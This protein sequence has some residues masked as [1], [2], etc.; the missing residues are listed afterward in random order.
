V[1]SGRSMRVSYTWSQAGTYLV[2][3]MAT[4]SNGAE[5]L[6]SSSKKVIIKESV[7]S[8][9]SAEEKGVTA[10]SGKKVCPCREK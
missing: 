7:R 1:N 4:D 3:V 6:W 2:Q 5:S 10:K 9:A 8:K